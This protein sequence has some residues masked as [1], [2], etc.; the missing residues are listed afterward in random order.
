MTQQVPVQPSLAC[1][2]CGRTFPQSDVVQVAGNWVCGD[3][4]PAYLSRVMAGT[5]STGRQWQYGGF[6]IRFLAIF[7]DGLLIDAVYFVT[8]LLIIPMIMASR[9]PGS[10]PAV[11]SVYV[12]LMSFVPLILAIL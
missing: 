5:A 8:V 11:L 2:Q 9:T 4:K 12:M 1:S 7:I 6:W 3:C 10:N